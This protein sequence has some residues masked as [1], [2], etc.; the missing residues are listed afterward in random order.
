MQAS[1][2]IPSLGG[3]LSNVL[4]SLSFIYSMLSGLYLQAQVAASVLFRVDQ[5]PAEKSMY[6]QRLKEQQQACL[7]FL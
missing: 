2:F 3:S 1:H 6:V 5:P 4:S 7:L